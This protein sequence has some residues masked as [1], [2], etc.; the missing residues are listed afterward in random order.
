L[1]PVFGFGGRGQRRQRVAKHCDRR[2]DRWEL[3]LED[4]KGRHRNDRTG[5]PS[6]C[7]GNRGRVSQVPWVRSCVQ[8]ESGGGLACG[9]S[10]RVGCECST[11][12]HA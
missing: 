5:C 6:D 8:R 7:L 11:S 4:G 2:Y 10:I 3:A 9:C 12:G 1:D